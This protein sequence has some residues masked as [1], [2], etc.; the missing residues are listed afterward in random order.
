MRAFQSVLKSLFI[1][2]L[3]TYLTPLF[4][5]ELLPDESWTA[6]L[7]FENDL[8]A[9]TDR[10]YTNGIK[11]SWISPDLDHFRDSDKL[12]EWSKKWIV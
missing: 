3:F 5:G 2:I 11:L 8:F 1:L 4:A 6:T 7:R 10:N 12:P 9:D